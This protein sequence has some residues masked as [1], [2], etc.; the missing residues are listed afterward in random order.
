MELSTLILV[1]DVGCGV[2]DVR[3]TLQLLVKWSKDFSNLIG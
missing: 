2:E 3:D 1:D